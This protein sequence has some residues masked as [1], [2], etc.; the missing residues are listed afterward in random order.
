MSACSREVAPVPAHGLDESLLVLAHATAVEQVVG[1]KIVGHC[2]V[3]VMD[4]TRLIHLWRRV[5]C[6]VVGSFGC[7]DITPPILVP[8]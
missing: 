3:L 6:G 2:G 1:Q 8:A 5:M 7:L 4:L